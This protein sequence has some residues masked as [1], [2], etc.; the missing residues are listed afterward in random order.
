MLYNIVGSLST[1]LFIGCLWGLYE[2]IKKIKKR[3][4][5]YDYT[6]KNL[7]Y[8]TQSISVNGF[9]S[10][11]IAFYAF[12]IYSIFLDNIDYFIFGTRLLASLVTLYILFLIYKDRTALKEKLPFTIAFI[13]MILSIGILFFRE[14]SMIIGKNTSIT[15]IITS[16]IIMFQGGISQI[17]TIFKHKCTGALSLKMNIIFCLKDVMNII[18]GFVIGI[19]DGW[20]L[21]LMGTISAF[22]KISVIFQFYIYQINY[23]KTSNIK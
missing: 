9:F 6:S 11:F 17:I 22:L 10:S 8:A 18:F 5:E 12:Y 3:E 19:A 16:T 14:E 15:I 2:Q 4:L 20:P 21:I 7:A 13:A 23:I 1:L